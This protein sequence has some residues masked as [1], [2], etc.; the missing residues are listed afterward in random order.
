MLLSDVNWGSSTQAVTFINAVN[1]ALILS[2]VDEHF[3]NFRCAQVKAVLMQI[4]FLEFHSFC[5]VV[6]PSVS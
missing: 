5:S 4:W 6:D 1:N 2:A 3:K